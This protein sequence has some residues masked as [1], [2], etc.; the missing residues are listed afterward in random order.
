MQ[1]LYP[2]PSESE[3]RGAQTL[4]VLLPGGDFLVGSDR[5]D[6]FPNP[7]FLEASEQGEPLLGVELAQLLLLRRVVFQ[8]FGSLH[9]QLCCVS[10]FETPGNRKMKKICI[11]CIEFGLM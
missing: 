2:T 6:R 11:Q 4:K 9:H 7:G 3:S 5:D 1:G 8:L 10:V